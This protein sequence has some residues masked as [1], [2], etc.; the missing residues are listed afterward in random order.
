[1]SAKL[2]PDTWSAGTERNWNELNER[3]DLENEP[4]LIYVDPDVSYELFRTRNLEPL[5]LKA[6]APLEKV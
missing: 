2:F 1:M 6:K 4:Y 5:F 3:S